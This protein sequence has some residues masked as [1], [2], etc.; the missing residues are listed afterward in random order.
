[1]SA[2]LGPNPRSPGGVYAPVMSLTCGVPRRGQRLRRG[3]VSARSTT[4]LK[5]FPAGVLDVAEPNW[6]M[7][8]NRR[9][10]SLQVGYGTPQVL[11]FRDVSPARRRGPRL[12]PRLPDM[13]HLISLCPVRVS[14]SPLGGE[15]SIGADW[16]ST[17]LERSHR[18]FKE[19][20][21]LFPKSSIL[22]SCTIDLAISIR[23][24]CPGGA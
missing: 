9:G 21:R 6:L 7:S 5:R 14:F 12:L 18:F 1:M 13:S 22:R 24:R 15:H 3:G 23:S 8:D 4:L 17:V 19:T 11:K 16:A 20:I 2:R 10:A